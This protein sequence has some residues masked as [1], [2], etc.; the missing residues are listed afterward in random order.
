VP[1]VL[2]PAGKTR[3]DNEPRITVASGYHW[4]MVVRYARVSNNNRATAPARR[5]KRP[6]PTDALTHC[7]NCGH[8]PSSASERLLL[9]Q[10]LALTWLYPDPDP[11]RPGQIREKIHCF[12]CQPHENLTIIE[13]AHCADGPLLIGPLGAAA[14]NNSGS[15]APV[16]RWLTQHGWHHGSSGWICRRHT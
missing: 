15:S 6:P 11:D 10:D 8:Q 7:P 2:I 1:R 12:A 5:W 9:R 14:T 16:H 4:R 3:I 13:C